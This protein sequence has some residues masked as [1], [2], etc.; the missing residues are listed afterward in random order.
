MSKEIE[1]IDKP[2]WII[3]LRFK[4]YELYSYVHRILVQIKDLTN[5]AFS[6]LSRRE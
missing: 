3:E 1:L 6:I 4:D 2:I 5:N